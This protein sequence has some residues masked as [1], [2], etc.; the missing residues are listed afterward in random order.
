MEEALLLDTFK[1]RLNKTLQQGTA[2]LWSPG[3][4]TRKDHDVFFST[5]GFYDSRN[6]SQL[7]PFFMVD[8]VSHGL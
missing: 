2:L 3:R 6:P 1:T 8:A 4:R 5:P 7:F